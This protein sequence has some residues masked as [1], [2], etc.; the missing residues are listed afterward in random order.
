MNFKNM[1]KIVFFLLLV[2]CKDKVKTLAGKYIEDSEKHEVLVFKNENFIFINEEIQHH[3]TYICCDTL[4]K[5]KYEILSEGN[6]LKLKSDI[7]K[8]DA[9]NFDLKESFNIK[10]KDSVFFEFNNPVERHDNLDEQL[11]YKITMITSK[12]VISLE[13]TSNVLRYE[14]VDQI[15]E[16]SINIFVKSD[17]L[18]Q[19]IGIRQVNLFP[20]IYKLK[21]KNSNHFKINIPDLTFEYLNFERINGEYVRTMKDGSLIWRDKKIKK[22]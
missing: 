21:N 1:I 10:N 4:S 17:A 16:I 11:L 15:E 13:S 19:N 9:L 12:D 3:P 20:Y 2:S 5:G 22:K 18:I 7:I 6:F 14:Y 8:L